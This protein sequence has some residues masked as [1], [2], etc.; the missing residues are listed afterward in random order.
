M[1]YSTRYIVFF[2]CSA[3]IKM[4]YLNFI[5]IINIVNRVFLCRLL[6]CWLCGTLTVVTVISAAENANVAQF[7]GLVKWI[8]MGLVVGGVVFVLCI[9]VELLLL[10]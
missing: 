9:V 10:L 3:G 8:T 6:Q 2:F 7:L 5:K 4:V 1:A